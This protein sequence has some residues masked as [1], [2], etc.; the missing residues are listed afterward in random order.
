MKPRLVRS[1]TEYG[2]FIDMGGDI[3]GL[4]HVSEMEVGIGK[5]KYGKVLLKTGDSVKVE[6]LAPCYLSLSLSFPLSLSLSPSLSVFQF[7]LEAPQCI[8]YVYGFAT[9][10][11]FGVMFM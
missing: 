9:C 5:D 3:Q 7:F 2:V 6:A 11:W 1:V 4:L 10:P 8:Q